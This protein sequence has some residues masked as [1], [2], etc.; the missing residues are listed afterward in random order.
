M[1][2][3]E[4]RCSCGALTATATGEP[5]RVSVC[6]CLDCKRRSGSAFSW[7]ATY[8]E[9]QVALRGEDASFTRTSD[10]GFWA[11]H[12]F[13][14]NCGTRVYYAIERRPAMISIPAGLFADPAF[15]APTIEVYGERRC[16]WLAELAPGQE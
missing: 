7:N 11:R 3:R 13:C 6:N 10:D 12:H 8:A 1:T 14:P 4:A 15:P 9:D 2:T 5:V 16:P